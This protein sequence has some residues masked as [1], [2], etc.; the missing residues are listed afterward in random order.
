MSARTD[1]WIENL[2]VPRRP[3]E[4]EVKA[5][6]SQTGVPVPRGLRLDPAAK[7]AV[8]D[9][10]APYVAKVCSADV[11]HK[12]DRGGVVLG[13]DAASLPG[14]VAKLRESFPGARVLVEEQLRIQG[15]ELIVGG[16]VDAN[17]GPAVMLGAGGILTELYRDVTFRLAPFGE[18][19]ARRMI[20]DLKISPLFE[21][22]RGI[23]LPADELARTLVRVGELALELGPDFEQL[24]LNPLVF[25]GDRFVALDAKLILAPRT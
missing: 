22:F 13:L 4:F 5:L 14:A 2:A 12:T 19:E 11:L 6:L 9:F 20:E 23:R 17:L 18:A 7:V 25:A 24:D 1:A 8:P 15:S 21:G 3:D 10:P 16:L